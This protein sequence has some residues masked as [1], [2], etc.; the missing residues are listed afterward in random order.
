M[1]EELAKGGGDQKSDHRYRSDTGDQ[2]PT[3]ADLGVTKLQSSR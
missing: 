2:V 1:G 3:L